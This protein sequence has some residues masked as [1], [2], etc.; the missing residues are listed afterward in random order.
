MF[1]FIAETVC[2]PVDDQSHSPFSLKCKSWLP[3]LPESDKYP[4]CRDTAEK[5]MTEMAETTQVVPVI[6]AFSGHLWLRIS[7]NMYSTRE[8]FNKLKD[9][10]VDKFLN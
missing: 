8:D 10:M 2:L 6:V 3:R 5:Q 4:V 1:I 9:V 7:A